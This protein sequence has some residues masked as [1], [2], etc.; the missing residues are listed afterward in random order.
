MLADMRFFNHIVI[1]YNVCAL[2]F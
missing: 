1:L 2:L